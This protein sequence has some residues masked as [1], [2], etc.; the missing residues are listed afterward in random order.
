MSSGLGEPKSKLK[1]RNAAREATLAAFLYFSTFLTKL[2]GLLLWRLLF[3]TAKL[4]MASRP[5]LYS[6]FNSP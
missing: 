6:V 5:L 2:A 1:Y 3:W 4:I